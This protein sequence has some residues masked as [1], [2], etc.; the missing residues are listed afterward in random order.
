MRAFSLQHAPVDDH[1][2]GAASF[3]DGE[4]RD[5]DVGD[6]AILLDRAFVADQRHDLALDRADAAEA[7][8]A[9]DAFVRPTPRLRRDR[10][11]RQAANCRRCSS[12]AVAGGKTRLPLRDLSAAVAPS[13]SIRTSGRSP[14]GASAMPNAAMTRPSARVRVCHRQNHKPPSTMSDER[15]TGNA[16]QHRHGAGPRRH[17]LA[18]AHHQLDA[19]PHGPKRPR[20]EAERHGEQAQHRHGHDEQA[21]KRRGDQIGDQPVMR[22]AMEVVDGKR[23]DGRAGHQRGQR[24]TRERAPSLCASSPIAGSHRRASLGRAPT[25]TH[26]ARRARPPRRTTSRSSDRTTIQAR[27]SEWRARRAR[28]CAW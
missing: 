15:L 27:R 9:E 10:R 7:V 13:R 23:R 24:G 8:A 6:A 16:R 2:R 4:R 11:R 18:G 26:R 22:H 19:E 28:R 20:L 21:N 5:D 3:A 17:P 1:P 25:A 12:A 14:P